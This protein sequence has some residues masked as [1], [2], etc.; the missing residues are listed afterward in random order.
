M[1]QPPQKHVIDSGSTSVTST[2]K[3][4]LEIVKGV[5]N[6]DYTANPSNVKVGSLVTGMVLQ[7]DV[8]SDVPITNANPVYFDWYIGYN[9]DQGQTLPNPGA[10]GSSDLM[11]QVFH[12]D[13]SL[14]PVPSATTTSS[15]QNHPAVWRTYVKIPKS[16]RKIMRGDVIQF[17]FKFDTAVKMWLKVKAIYYEVYP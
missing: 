7:I 14:I 1:V 9:I 13:G 11:G 17:V 16:Y 3:S 5:L 6:P 8:V 4:T 12:E 10:V 15:A 2:A